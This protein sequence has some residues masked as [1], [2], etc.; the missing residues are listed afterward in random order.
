MPPDDGEWSFCQPWTGPPTAQQVEISCS[1]RMLTAEDENKDTSL[2]D[3]S[4]SPSFQRNRL[5]ASDRHINHKRKNMK[6]DAKDRKNRSLSN[7][8]LNKVDSMDIDISALFCELSDNPVEEQLKSRKKSRSPSMRAWNPPSNKKPVL[9]SFKPEYNV[10]QPNAI[11]TLS[12]QFEK[13]PSPKKKTIPHKKKIEL[14]NT[15][16]MTK[17]RRIHTEPVQEKNEK[18]SAKLRTASL[19]EEFFY[20]KNKEISP[21]SVKT[22]RS[23]WEKKALSTPAAHNLMLNLNNETDRRP[24]Y[25]DN[26]VQSARQNQVSKEYKQRVTTSVSSLK[27]QFENFSTPSP[28]LIESTK[29]SSVKSHW[30][31]FQKC[32][33]ETPTDK[34]LVPKMII[35][36]IRAIKNQFEQKS[37]N[38][39]EDSDKLRPVRNVNA[40]KTSPLLNLLS[41]FDP[42]LSCSSQGRDSTSS[43]GSFSDNDVFASEENSNTRNEDKENGDIFVSPLTEK[44]VKVKAGDY[45]RKCKRE[46]E[47]ELKRLKEQRDR[48]AIMAEKREVERMKKMEE[49]SEKEL[50]EKEREQELKRIEAERALQ[51]KRLEEEKKLEELQRANDKEKQRIAIE[52]EV[53]RAKKLR[54]DEKRKE[55]EEKEGIELQRIEEEKE[56]EEFER[57]KLVEAREYMEEQ[58]QKE[59]EEKLKEEEEKIKQLQ[60]QRGLYSENDLCVGSAPEADVDNL[61]NKFEKTPKQNESDDENSPINRPLSRVGSNASLNCRPLNPDEMQLFMGM[62]TTESFMRTQSLR[63]K[64]KKNT[65]RAGMKRSNSMSEKS[66][67]Q[68]VS[69]K[70]RRSMGPP[71]GNKVPSNCRQLR[72]E[73]WKFFLGEESSSANCD[74]NFSDSE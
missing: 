47:E 26:S 38:R 20:R 68:L 43:S 3:H 7:E 73:E 36:S 4:L 39:K 55:F 21:K 33:I 11:A 16:E 6:K 23:D 24:S 63:V 27:N 66:S 30:F 29:K 18:D 17:R 13:T 31:K 37:S 71:V 51:R 10:L 64:K 69:N 14:Y 19:P 35:S 61:I 53:K 25:E 15:S 48:E 42:S 54:E 62:T 1:L 58:L 46:K 59:K 41:K 45:L 8:E 2:E 34:N 49:E 44:R 65:S 70:S 12:N 32:E 50:K 56:V 22:L 28:N 40:S 5:T 9:S 60:I 67:P 52:E 57:K 72:D 74:F